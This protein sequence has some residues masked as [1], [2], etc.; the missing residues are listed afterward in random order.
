MANVSSIGP[1]ARSEDRHDS[2]SFGSCCTTVLSSKHSDKPQKRVISQLTTRNWM[3]HL[4]LLHDLGDPLVAHST[5]SVFL[6]ML[7][8]PSLGFLIFILFLLSLF[9]TMP[10]LLLSLPFPKL[11]TTLLPPFSQVVMDVFPR[12]SQGWSLGLS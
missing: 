9:P 2:P 12:V 7:V 6:A 11:R 4:F 8:S 1:R 5:V 3:F 10:Q